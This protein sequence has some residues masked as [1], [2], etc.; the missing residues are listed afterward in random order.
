M[1]EISFANLNF[2]IV[3]SYKD[4]KSRI[5]NEENIRLFG[6]FDAKATVCKFW[7]L[8]GGVEID[9]EIDN[10]DASTLSKID[11]ILTQEYGKPDYIVKGSLKV[12]KQKDCY[13]IHGMDEKQY[14]VDVHI[15]QVCFKKPYYFMLDYAKYD[16]YVEILNEISA[17]RGLV[18]NNHLV[19]VGKRMLAWMNTE[20]YEYFL[21]FSR[22]KFAFYSSQKKKENERTCLIPSW[23][24]EGKYK[25]IED[26]HNQLESFFS[27]L[28][29]Y[30]LSI[31][32]D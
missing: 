21:S 13:I 26:L 14:Q 6:E 17:K 18:W 31:K 25:T 2:N 19:V 9:F 15:L 10:Q 8:F 5:E 30:D 16:R 3:D 22:N 32:R 24:I 12:W 1:K 7:G 27:Y 4:M 28:E 20:N 29:E 11:D 23:N